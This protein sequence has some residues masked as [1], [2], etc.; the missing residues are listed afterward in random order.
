LDIEVSQNIIDSL[1]WSII[2]I[3]YT[4]AEITGVIESLLRIYW[5][6]GTDWVPFNPPEGG[7]NTAENYV[8]ANVTHF[9]VYGVFLSPPYCGDNV[10]YGGE[11]CSSC[12]Q[13]CG[14]CPPSPGPGPGAGGGGGGGG[15]GGAPTGPTTPTTTTTTVAPTAVCGNGICESGESNSNC[16]ADCP[17]APT[18]TTTPTPTTPGAPA[19]PSPITGFVVFVSSPLGIS[20]L[21]SVIIA[22]V[23]IIVFYKKWY[24]PRK[25]KKE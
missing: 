15:G 17:A 5:F 14:T 19:A 6:N 8:W 9:S 11:G 13:D 10:C 21:L 23:L 25:I 1:Q 20:L 7:V 3:Y 16:P 22:A 2:K 18:T 24:I 12:P 4:D